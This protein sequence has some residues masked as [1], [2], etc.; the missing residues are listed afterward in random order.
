MAA[1]GARAADRGVG[2]RGA[3]RDGN[4]DMTGF[5]IFRTSAARRGAVASGAGLAALAVAT[6]SFAADIGGADAGG[7]LSGFLHPIFGF[8]HLLAMVAVGLLSVQIGGRAIWTVPATFVAALG[9]GGALG[10]FGVALPQVEGAIALSV[11]A[12]G[13]VIALHGPLLT[14]IAMAFVAFFAMFHGHAHGVEMPRLDAPEFYFLGFMAAS[15]LLHLTGVGLGFL[16]RRKDA[17]ALLGAGVCGVG[18]HMTLLTYG[19]A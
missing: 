8:D 17:R 5:Q 4:I 3:A 10:V 14:P 13:L 1:F 2:P 16:Q 9:L 15:A 7:F 12:L 11:F 6:P 18:A 19:V